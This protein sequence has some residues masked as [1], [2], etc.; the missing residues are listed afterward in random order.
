MKGFII[1]LYRQVRTTRNPKQSVKLFCS[2]RNSLQPAGVRFIFSA[3]SFGLAH[4]HG[5]LG[6]LNYDKDIVLWLKGS[7]I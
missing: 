2:D 4:K 6:F 3:F 7:K 5:Q 1:W